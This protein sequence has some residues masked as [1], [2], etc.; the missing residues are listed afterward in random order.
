MFDDIIK[1]AE[2]DEFKKPDAELWKKVSGE[3]DKKIMKTLADY[4]NG[5]L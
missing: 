3:L 1:D 2:K 4:F 5:T